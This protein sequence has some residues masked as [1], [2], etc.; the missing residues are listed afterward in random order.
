MQT[1]LLR[2]P[3]EVFWNSCGCLPFSN[4]VALASRL[5]R[6]V[7]VHTSSGSLLI[8]SPDEKVYFLSSLESSESSATDG[9]VL[10]TL[11]ISPTK[12]LLP[13][14]FEEKSEPDLPFEK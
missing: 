3:V 13:L 4:W 5:R 6:P 9:P 7:R 11:Y 2:A 8:S 14:L 1:L 10:A 12:A